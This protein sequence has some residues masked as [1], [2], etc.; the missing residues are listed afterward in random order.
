MSKRTSRE[1][2]LAHAARSKEYTMAR[3][4]LVIWLSLFLLLA[5]TAFPVPARV[6]VERRTRQSLIG[7]VT[8]PKR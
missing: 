6:R 3:R 8:L 2:V 7:T 4:L 1:L 5:A